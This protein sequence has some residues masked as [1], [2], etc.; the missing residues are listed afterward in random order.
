MKWRGKIYIDG[1]LPK[2]FTALA[3]ALQW[4]IAKEGVEY[5][6]LP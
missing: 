2:I 6:P 1:M 4:C 3:D 5:I